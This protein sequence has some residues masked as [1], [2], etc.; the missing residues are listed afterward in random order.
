MHALK[1]IECVD[2]PKIRG[3]LRC[4]LRVGVVGQILQGQQVALAPLAVELQHA[5]RGK[6]A[7]QLPGG[8][9]IQVG[10]QNPCHGRQRDQMHQR[11]QQPVGARADGAPHAPADQPAA[12]HAA[13]RDGQHRRKGKPYRRSRPEHRVEGDERKAAQQRN[14][15]KHAKNHTRAPRQVLVAVTEKGVCKSA[16]HARAHEHGSAEYRQH[17]QRAGKQ[18]GVHVLVDRTQRH[19]HQHDAAG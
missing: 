10:G 4:G 11:R 6:A 13:Q 3:H 18:A 16:R 5:A 9:R 12:R 17:A 15:R 2:L 1:G 8:S 14:R 7:P 19:Q